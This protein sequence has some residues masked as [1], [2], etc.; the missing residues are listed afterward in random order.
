M[1]GLFSRLTLMTHCVIMPG[2]YWKLPE[3]SFSE[4]TNVDRK[5]NNIRKPTVWLA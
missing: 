2:Q 3:P 5:T 4:N 1:V